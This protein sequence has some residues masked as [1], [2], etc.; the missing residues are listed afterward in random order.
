VD[1]LDLGRVT[2]A[3]HVETTW[4]LYLPVEVITRV[5][6]RSYLDKHVLPAFNSPGQDHPSRGAGPAGR[7]RSNG[8]RMVSPA[9]VE[10]S[11][12]LRVASW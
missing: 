1:D 2:F 11:P 4:W 5:A 8:L 10:K 6:H 7:Y 9:V 12:T 3:D